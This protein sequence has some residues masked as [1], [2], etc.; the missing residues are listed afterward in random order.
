MSNKERVETRIEAEFRKI[1]YK[2]NP[3]GDYTEEIDMPGSGLT[4][5]DVLDHPWV[6]DAFINDDDETFHVYVSAESEQRVF[7]N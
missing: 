4:I 7:R 2:P 1:R 3:D 6:E 5:D